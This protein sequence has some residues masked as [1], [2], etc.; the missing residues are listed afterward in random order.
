MPTTYL[1]RAILD[2]LHQAQHIVDHHLVQC[3]MCRHKR[4]CAQRADAERVFAKYQRLP[5]RTPGLTL[6]VT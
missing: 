6:G 5:R 3:P 2:Q 4:A 1:S